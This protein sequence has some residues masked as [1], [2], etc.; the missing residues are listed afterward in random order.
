MLYRVSCHVPG[1]PAVFSDAGIKNTRWS[2]LQRSLYALMLLSFSYLAVLRAASTLQRPQQ[3]LWW[4]P[5]AMRGH[6][7]L[8]EEPSGPWHPSSP[9]YRVLRPDAARFGRRRWPRPTRS[10][11]RRSGRATAPARRGGW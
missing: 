6:A 11:R 3:A 8:E 5:G 7:W 1:V 2:W 4:R 10:P 9:P